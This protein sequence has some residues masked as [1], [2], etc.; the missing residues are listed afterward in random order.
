[1]AGRWYR[2]RPVVPATAFQDESEPYPGHWR[3]FPTPWARPV[4]SEELD[5][6]LRSL[7]TPWRDILL[8]PEVR[9]AD[10]HDTQHRDLLAR[11][12]AA[13]RDALD[14]TQRR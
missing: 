6:A 8:R 14:A 4:T 11:A 12:R 1:M 2:P 7:P 3:E 5:Q 10:L 9:S 13:L